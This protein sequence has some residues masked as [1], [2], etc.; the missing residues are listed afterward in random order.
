MPFS[1][2]SKNVELMGIDIVIACHL[3][4]STFIWKTLKPVKSTAPI[5]RSRLGRSHNSLVDQIQPSSCH[6]FA[7]IEMARDTLRYIDG[8][9]SWKP[10]G[11]W[12]QYFWLFS[13][14]KIECSTMLFWQE[15]LSHGKRLTYALNLNHQRKMTWMMAKKDDWDMWLPGSYRSFVWSAPTAILSDQHAKARGSKRRAKWRKKNGANGLH[16]KCAARWL[17][18]LQFVGFSIELSQKDAGWRRN[19]S[20]LFWMSVKN[21]T[22]A[23]EPSLTVHPNRGQLRPAGEVQRIELGQVR[24]F[25]IYVNLCILRFLLVL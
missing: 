8:G 2:N 17:L 7:A 25:Q 23:R 15:P 5:S 4:W 12:F 9:T 11:L 16:G 3:E 20:R 19:M 18:K 10:T 1:F 13:P 22:H 14:S 24:W 6:L 21:F